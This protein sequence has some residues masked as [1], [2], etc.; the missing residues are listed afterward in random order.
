MS[1]AARSQ[2]TTSALGLFVWRERGFWPTET[3][4]QHDVID[5]QK[6]FG[7]RYRLTF[8]PA[9][10]SRGKHT[11]DP[12]Y[13]QIPC[14]YGIIY[15]V[16]GDDLAIEVDYHDIIAA[17]LKRLGLRLTQ[18][19]DN[20]K[21]LVFS[22]DRF[23]EVAAIVKPK[24]RLVLTESQKAERLARLANRRDHPEPPRNGHTGAGGTPATASKAI[25]VG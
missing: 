23:P 20:E 12:W 11:P 16:G 6:R 8:D 9:Y 18:D 15:P 22:V 7:K 3:T 17:K 2:P 4:M 19:G 5:L 10:D 21:T 25:S 1:I 14:R 13:M 24:R